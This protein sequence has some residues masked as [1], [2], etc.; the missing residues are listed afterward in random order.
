VEAVK[1]SALQRAL[2]AF[3]RKHKRDLP[4]R[5]TR[6]P[7]AIWVS[8]IML[9]QTQ[10]QTVE[11]RFGEFLRQFPTVAALAAADE[12]TVC[13]AWAGLGY[14][15]RAR[16]LHKAASV[17][18]AEHGGVLPSAAA[19]LRR[20]PGIGA[21][22]SAAIAS[23]AF[24]EK[25]AAVDGN[26]VRVLSRVFALP[27]RADE[28]DL[29]KRVRA[30]ADLLVQT[31]R[32]GDINQALMDIGA[33]ICRSDGAACAICPLCGTCRASAEGRP[34][35]YPGKKKRTARKALPV[36]F[37]WIERDGQVLLEQRGLDGLWPGLW[38]L[39]GAEGPAAKATLAKRLGK[40]LGPALASVA[41]TLTH[42]D[43]TATIYKASKA[44]T[45]NK[46]GQRWWRD[47]LTAP[48]SAL[49]RK[50]I[51]A[52]LAIRTNRTAAARV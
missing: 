36:A 32:P 51:R 52:T 13:E 6:D 11:P 50:A 23:I 24:N 3:Y 16:H 20:L 41:H 7:Y 19:E 42:R 17:V 39:P 40:R 30:H 5:R 2:Q 45:T 10:V 18:F 15:R 25:I 21:Y 33:T 47:P 9:Q 28:P 38:Q 8:E 22:T 34:V 29:I 27:G 35:D 31:A 1:V 26:L 43:V 12:N 48:L 44:T 4:W 49:A 14:Y 46:P 37:A